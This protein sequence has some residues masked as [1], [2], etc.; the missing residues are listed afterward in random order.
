MKTVF[1][2]GMVTLKTERWGLQLYCPII[3]LKERSLVLSFSTV[4]VVT[5]K[6]WQF[7]WSVGFQILGFGFGIGKYKEQS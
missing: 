5:S 6:T 3:K 7:N 4:F 1:D 2:P